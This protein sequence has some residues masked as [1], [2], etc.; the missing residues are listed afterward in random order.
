MANQWQKGPTIRVRQ[1]VSVFP[2][3]ATLFRKR[4][5]L[6]FASDVHQRLHCGVFAMPHGPDC[7]AR[8]RSPGGAPSPR[9]VHRA[10]RSERVE[11]TSVH[12]DRPHIGIFD[13]GRSNRG[14]FFYGHVET[15][16]TA[17]TSPT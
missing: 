4:V 7:T 9:S 10:L 5:T 8:S 1:R 12:R 17:R 2:C 3:L 15:E 13:V 14:A 11:V 16:C 6:R